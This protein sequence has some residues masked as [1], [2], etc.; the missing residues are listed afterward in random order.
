MM[1]VQGIL[2]ALLVSHSTLL[3]LLRPRDHSIHPAD[4]HILLNTISST[5]A[6]R[7]VNSESWIP[8]CLPRFNSRGFL[9][10]FISY[11]DDSSR[12]GNDEVSTS[13]SGIK[14]DLGLGI[15]LVT[16]DKEGF[17]DMRSWKDH[18]VSKLVSVPASLSS[19]VSGIG[20]SSLY[21]RLC[22]ALVSQHNSGS[23]EMSNGKATASKA[24]GLGHPVRHNQIP[25]ILPIRHFWYKSKVHV[26]I[27]TPCCPTN[28]DG[29]APTSSFTGEYA[30]SAIRRRGLLRQYVMVREALQSP[31][32]RERGDGAARLVYL[33]TD[34]QAVLGMVSSASCR[35]S[36]EAHLNFFSQSTATHELYICLPSSVPKA[37]ATEAAHAL[38]RWIRKNERKLFLTSASTL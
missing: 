2:Y 31:V 11:F 10:A 25:N 29:T 7:T 1:I 37:T 38:A 33:V 4:L 5:E 21:K 14:N 19:A 15:V 6:L 16:A 8:I 3:T 17:F 26:Q 22:Q 23:T 9:H 20:Q 18:I 13:P 30:T 27:F 36:Q 35:I 24:P 32:N 34:A 12:S 28:I